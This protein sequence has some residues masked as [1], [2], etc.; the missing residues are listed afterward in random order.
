MPSAEYLK[1]HKVADLLHPTDSL[2]LPDGT[3]VLN[4]VVV[5]PFSV[6]AP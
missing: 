6:T 4:F 2:A 5:T 1:V 3:I